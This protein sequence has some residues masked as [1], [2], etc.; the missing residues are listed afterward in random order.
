MSYFERKHPHIMIPG[1]PPRFSEFLQAAWQVPGGNAIKR[2]K[3]MG[4]SLEPRCIARAGAFANE[5]VVDR[6]WREPESERDWF[7]KPSFEW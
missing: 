7:E 4:L 1:R 5:V 2:I 3:I 6:D